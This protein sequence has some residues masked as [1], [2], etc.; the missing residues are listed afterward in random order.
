MRSLLAVGLLVACGWPFV[1]VAVEMSDDYD[2]FFHHQLFITAT[3][4]LNPS[5]VDNC[6]MGRAIEDGGCSALVFRRD[7]GWLC[8]PDGGLY[9]PFHGLQ[10][11]DAGP[12]VS[13]PRNIAP[14]SNLLLFTNTDDPSCRA[15]LAVPAG[16]MTVVVARDS[17]GACTFTTR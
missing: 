3:K 16:G 5:C 13:P 8:E 6:E 12:I 9:Y 17:A 15:N 7:G 1:P 2:T 11:P 14:G 4:K 10:A